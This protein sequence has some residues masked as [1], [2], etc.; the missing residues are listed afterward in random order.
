MYEEGG[1]QA[2]RAG[3]LSGVKRGSR[4]RSSSLQ[5]CPIVGMGKSCPDSV[6]PSPW[7]SFKEVCRDLVQKL[8]KKMTFTT[9]I[10][11]ILQNTIFIVEGKLWLYIH[12]PMCSMPLSS[13]KAIWWL[14]GFWALSHRCLW[15][16]RPW[17]AAT[18]PLCLGKGIT[19]F[20]K[21][22]FQKSCWLLTTAN[23]ALL[24]FS[25]AL[26]RGKYLVLYLKRGII[27]SLH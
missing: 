8:E 9:H 1:G 14:F 20:H 26:E 12:D 25:L 19:S 17:G 13:E 5:E 21:Y 2:G 24:Q 15:S 22:D 23:T 18:Q 11:H 6:M 3:D 27:C 7:L 4:R 16:E 10:N